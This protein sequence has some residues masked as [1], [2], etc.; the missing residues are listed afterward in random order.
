VRPIGPLN[1]NLSGRNGLKGSLFL[2]GRLVSG[3]I[4]KATSNGA[5]Q[6]ARPVVSGHATHTCQW[7]SGGGGNNSVP[8]K[9]AI[10]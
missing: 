4:M 10:R 5:V 1:M 8:V 6:V 3:A 9:S 7:A 2:L